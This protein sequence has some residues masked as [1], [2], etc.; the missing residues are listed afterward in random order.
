MTEQ[1]LLVYTHKKWLIECADFLKYFSRPMFALMTYDAY[2]VLS[3]RAILAYDGKWHD[4]DMS[5]SVFQGRSL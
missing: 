5:D 1:S 3:V 4:S 2:S